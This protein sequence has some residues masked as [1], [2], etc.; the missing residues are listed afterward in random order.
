[1]KKAILK[2]SI[3]FFILTSCSNDNEIPMNSSE[4]LLKKIVTHNYETTYETIFTYNG[5]KIIRAKS[6]RIRIEFSYDGDNITQIEW[7]SNPDTDNV[8]SNQVNFEY[9]TDG[10]LKKFIRYSFYPNSVPHETVEFNYNNNGSVNYNYIAHYN[11]SYN[12]TGLFT[13]ANNEISSINTLSSI[14]G[15]GGTITYNYDTKNHPLKNVIGY[16]KLLLY[17]YF[18]PS[19]HSSGFS[20]NIGN[21]NNLI[22]YTY[23]VNQKTTQTDIVNSIEYNN[24]NFPIAINKDNVDDADFLFYN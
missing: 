17:Q 20:T 16:N 5:K 13:I 12:Q 19:I 2:I 4:V 15:P 11:S 23:F 1:M 22:S 21:N 7:Y 10:R 6:N 9:F 24:S 8:I 18:Y 3:L 14:N